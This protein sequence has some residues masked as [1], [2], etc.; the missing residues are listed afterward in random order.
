M[1]SRNVTYDLDPVTLR[2]SND[3]FILRFV[4]ALD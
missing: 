1:Q 3:H 4:I 2:I